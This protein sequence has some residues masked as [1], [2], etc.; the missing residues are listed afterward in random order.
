[1]GLGDVGFAAQN[2]SAHCKVT[3]ELHQSTGS[4]YFDWL[5][6]VRSDRSASLL[7]IA[8]LDRGLLAETLL[9]GGHGCPTVKDNMHII[10]KAVQTTSISGSEE[11]QTHHDKEQNNSEPHGRRQCFRCGL[12]SKHHCNALVLMPPGSPPSKTFGV[13]ERGNGARRRK[14]LGENKTS[15]AH[16]VHY[17]SAISLDL[18]PVGDH[19]SHRLG[20]DLLTARPCQRQ[21]LADDRNA[22]R[23]SIVK[24]FRTVHPGIP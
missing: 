6:G 20:L 11:S 22:R 4:R 5:W 12:Y 18:Q 14:T 16:P 8:P 3:N 13:P 24:S 17:H 10:A 2:T 7:L 9:R 21:R 23:S 1:L 15:Y 19:L